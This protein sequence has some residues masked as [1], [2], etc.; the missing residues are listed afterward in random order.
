MQMTQ[1]ANSLIVFKMSHIPKNVWHYEKSKFL[2][3]KYFN[4]AFEQIK[5]EIIFQFLQNYY[6]DDSYY[7]VP[8]VFKISAKL[9]SFHDESEARM[10]A[11]TRDEEIYQNAYKVGFGVGSKMK[12]WF[13]VEEYLPQESGKY[14]VCARGKISIATFHDGH[15]YKSKARSFL[16]NIFLTENKRYKT[17]T[18]W[19]QMPELPK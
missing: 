5:A 1:E 14:V 11:D 3:D 9:E 18:H 12:V 8:E 16:Y 7:G 10:S 17:V 4:F 2:E 15:F 13:P 19:T 6:R